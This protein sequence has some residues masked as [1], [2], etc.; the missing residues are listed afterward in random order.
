MPYLTIRS[1]LLVLLVLLGACRPAEVD[2][3]EEIADNEELRLLVEADQQDR[4][5]PDPAAMTEEKALAQMQRDAERRARVEAMLEAGEI[6]TLQDYVNAALIFQHGNDS[7]SYRKVF[8]LSREVLKIDSTHGDARQFYAMGYDR[9][10]LAVGKPQV[11][12]TQIS[13]DQQQGWHIPPVD[14]TAVTEAERL[15][16][17]GRTLA[18]RQAA[19]QCI[20][21]GGEPMACLA[22]AP[23]S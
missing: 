16:Y 5:D 23:D 21:D 17:T 1:V 15:W 4:S 6:R 8:E 9:Y 14:T 2:V 20:E 10:L 19:L 13:F 11:Y 7:A 18:D 12:A 3:E 22:G